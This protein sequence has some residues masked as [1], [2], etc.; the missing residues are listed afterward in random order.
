MTGFA[1]TGISCLLGVLIVGLV[2][3][4]SDSSEGARAIFI[5]VLA[6]GSL[7]LL[8]VV[9]RRKNPRVESIPRPPGP[10]PCASC[11]AVNPEELHGCSAC[12]E[13]RA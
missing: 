12:G 5:F 13:P 8:L 2:V 6:L 3:L 1:R 11:G 10:W 7:G 4:A 9:V